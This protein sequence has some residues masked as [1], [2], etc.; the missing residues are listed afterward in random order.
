MLGA[1]PSWSEHA[2]QILAAL[3]SSIDFGSRQQKQTANVV[4]S[5][6]EIGDSTEKAG[7][8]AG[9]P[10]SALADARHCAAVRLLMPFL[11]ASLMYMVCV[12]GSEILA[13]CLAAARLMRRSWTCAIRSA[14]QVSMSRRSSTQVCERPSWSAT[15]MVPWG[16]VSTSVLSCIASS[17]GVIWERMTFS[18][19]RARAE[20]ASSSGRMWAVI[21]GQPSRRTARSLPRPATSSQALPRGRTV[22]GFKRPICAMLAARV[23]IRSS[24]GVVRALFG[25]ETVIAAV[26]MDWKSGGGVE[27]LGGAD[28]EGAVVVFGDADVWL[29]GGEV[30]SAPGGGEDDGC[31]APGFVRFSEGGVSNNC[32]TPVTFAV[33]P[34]ILPTDGKTVKGGGGGGMGRPCW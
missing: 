21:C 19:S 5:T 34:V 32:F 20:S 10:A 9:S 25:S 7:V 23:A 4:V 12:T 30:L 33:K 28:G 1:V 27:D 16:C 2:L 29:G 15:P 17:T 14:G 26:A 6:G 18:L 11:A 31:G 3:V 8:S 24:L 13:R 22:M